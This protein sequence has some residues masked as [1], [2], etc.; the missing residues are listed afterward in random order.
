MPSTLGHPVGHEFAIDRDGTQV[1]WSSFRVG[2]TWA[3]VD[4]LPADSSFKMGLI[5]WST[6][7]LSSGN[8]GATQGFLGY[9]FPEARS[10]TAWSASWFGRIVVEVSS[11][12]VT[13]STGTWR[14]ID[15]INMTGPGL[16][17]QTPAQMRLPRTITEYNVIALRVSIYNTDQNYCSINDMHFWGDF[18]K[19]G[20]EFWHPTINRALYGSEFD[21]GDILQ[22]SV[23]TNSFRIKNNTAQIANNVLI[24]LDSTVNY[25]TLLAGSVLTD[26]VTPGATLTINT[27]ASGAISPVMS[28]QRTLAP[29]A[30]MGMGISRVKAVAG[31][32]T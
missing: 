3:T 22:G 4:T 30:P 14:Q 19:A 16:S 2:N 29:N 27:I 18:S 5:D 32:W 24:S 20:L 8:N 11:D 13:F 7:V 1:Y 21:L 28:V 6:A 10:L 9:M 23:T 26:G 17:I 25:G 15:T 31:S 12:A